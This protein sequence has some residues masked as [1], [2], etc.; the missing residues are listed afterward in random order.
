M[1]SSFT[2]PFNY[3]TTG[4]GKTQDKKQTKKLIWPAR[5]AG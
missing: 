4:E 1:F 2:E 5:V 3:V